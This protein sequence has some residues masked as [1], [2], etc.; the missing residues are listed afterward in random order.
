MCL[1]FFFFFNLKCTYDLTIALLHTYVSSTPW[2]FFFFFNH[3]RHSFLLL[4][5]VLYFRLSR[6]K[7]VLYIEPIVWLS[8][9]YGCREKNL[10]L[11][12]G[13]PHDLEN[14]LLGVFSVPPEGVKNRG[15]I[16]F[17]SSRSEVLHRLFLS[18]R[19]N[20]IAEKC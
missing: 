11:V 13:A 12:F 20:L 4:L 6:L 15:Q 16:C 17:L 10:C 5:W 1:F 7:F 19:W 14:C 8:R 3:S 18:R 9:M 2:F